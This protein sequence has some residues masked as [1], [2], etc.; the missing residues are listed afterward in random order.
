MAKN[1]YARGRIKHISDLTERHYRRGL[2][3]LKK[4]NKISPNQWKM[5]CAHYEHHTLT[6]KQLARKA[7]IKGGYRA[8]N[9]E[10]GRLAHLLWERLPLS[11]PPPPRHGLG[12][13]IGVLGSGPIV[14]GQDWENT[15]RPRL[16][17]ALKQLGWCGKTG[18]RRISNSPGSDGDALSAG[19]GGDLATT[20]SRTHASRRRRSMP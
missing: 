4:E 8:V 13:W 5:L 18:E 7:R 16:M 20:P 11:Q 1:T 3:D 10:Y 19:G 6:H 12:R 17:Q 15:M 9:R 2:V 14:R